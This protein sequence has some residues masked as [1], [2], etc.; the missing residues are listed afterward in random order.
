MTA[1]QVRQTIQAVVLGHVQYHTWYSSW[2]DV[3]DLP[4]ERDARFVVWDQWTA[5][6][7]N[8]VGAMDGLLFPQQLV[9]LYFL[10][11]AASDR[12]P[13]ERD[14]LVEDAHRAA[15]DVVLKLLRDHADDFGM[16]NV[17]ITTQFDEGVQLDTGVLLQFT[18]RG[19]EALC[20]D[21]SRFPDPEP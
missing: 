7:I 3:K 6:L 19:M 9:R 20:L 16:E 8:G 11:P 21:N 12:T 2:N 17:V 10:S 5:R 4:T 14:G 1:A 15:T 13:A 18:A